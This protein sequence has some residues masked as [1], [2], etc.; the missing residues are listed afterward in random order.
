MR[1]SGMLYLKDLKNY[2]GVSDTLEDDLITVEEARMSGTCD[3][4]TS[5]DPYM[6]WRDSTKTPNHV[7]WVSAK[8]AAGKSVLSGFIIN[9]LKAT[10]HPCSYFFF[11]HGDRTKSRLGACLRSLAFQMAKAHFSV[12]GRISI[13]NK[14]EANI[15]DDNERLVWRNLF[16]NGIFEATFPLTTG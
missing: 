9:D 1:A 7:F 5:K 12:Q 3:W 16:V 8:P 14:E 10:K 15:D 11:K 2:L 13:M 4:F 6:T